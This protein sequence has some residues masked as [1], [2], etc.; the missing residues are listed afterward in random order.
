MKIIHDESF[1]VPSPEAAT[2]L[3]TAQSMI[4]WATPTYPQ[5]F[6]DFSL[7]LVT[8]LRSCF[9]SRKNCQKERELMWGNYHR[10]RCTP[11][12]YIKWRDFMLTSIKCKPSPTFYQYITYEVF[13]NEINTMYESLEGNPSTQ[14]SLEMTKIEE[15]ALRY[16]AG[17]VCRRTRINLETSTHPH[18][19]EMIFCI[20]T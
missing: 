5:L 7:D 1:R 3:E 19:D 6:C 4:A 17:Y 15:N 18:K 13:I 14:T 12:F 10:L 11:E 16:V 9:T 20:L 2:A 8:N